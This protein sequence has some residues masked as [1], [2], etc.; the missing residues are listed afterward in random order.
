MIALCL[1][2]V[3]QATD[4]VATLTLDKLSVEVGEPIELVLDVR[5]SIDQTIHIEKSAPG[6]D[7]SW[8]VLA[9]EEPRTEPDA[10]HPGRAHTF[11]RFRIAS[12]E[13]GERDL[14]AQKVELGRGADTLAI[15]SPKAHVG[16]KGLL[17]EKEDAARPIKGFRDSLELGKQASK[18][19]WILALGVALSIVVGA[20]IGRRMRRRKA[21]PAIVRTPLA[22]L[23][24]LERSDLEA[25]DRAREAHFEL[26]RI[27]RG[28][29][30]DKSKTVRN[31]LADDEWLARA[32]EDAG[33][34]AKLAPAKDEI[35]ELLRACAEIKYGGSSATHWAARERV[36]KAR[37]I[38]KRLDEAEVSA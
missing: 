8:T 38:L 19:P 16:V 15:F 28:A 14:P 24:E 30:D 32:L 1:L 12:L 6:L 4:A 31:G 33:L 29:I 21:E 23:D 37:S 5:H 10:A 7:E 2:L 27:L 35:A 11:A 17:A 22:L 25:P 18:G 26:T 3:A 34:G 9:S 13:P 20:L 36:A